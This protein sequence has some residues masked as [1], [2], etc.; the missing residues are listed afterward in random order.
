MSKE[1]LDELCRNI[2][3]LKLELDKLQLQR[4]TISKQMDT[5]AKTIEALRMEVALGA[6]ALYLML[7][8]DTEDETQKSET[9]H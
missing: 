3:Y 1:H 5:I 2:G 7:V 4:D 8:A 6:F 9:I